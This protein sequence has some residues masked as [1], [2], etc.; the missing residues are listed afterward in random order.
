MKIQW[1][2]DPACQKKFSNPQ[3]IVDAIVVHA[4]TFFAHGS[5]TTRIKLD[6]LPLQ[7]FDTTLMA[8]TN[9]LK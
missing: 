2:C 5:L 8:T 1:L 9:N 4:N 3:K 6:P 7:N